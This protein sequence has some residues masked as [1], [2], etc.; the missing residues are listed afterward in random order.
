MSEKNNKEEEIFDFITPYLERVGLEEKKEKK[1]S[2]EKH[3]LDVSAKDVPKEIFEIMKKEKK[4]T[5]VIAVEIV[6]TLM[7]ILMLLGVIPFF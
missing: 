6:L 1:E 7:L 4:I 3:H 2:E 5:I